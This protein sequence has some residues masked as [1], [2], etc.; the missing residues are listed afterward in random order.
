MATNGVQQRGDF[1]RS[2]HLASLAQVF[3]H[4]HGTWA[5]FGSFLQTLFGERPSAGLGVAPPGIVGCRHTPGGRHYPVLQASIGEPLS[6]TMFDHE[7][8]RRPCICIGSFDINKNPGLVVTDICVKANRFL[9]SIGRGDEADYSG[10]DR[11]YSQPL[12]PSSSPLTAP[13]ES[14]AS[15]SFRSIDPT[16][17]LDSRLRQPGGERAGESQGLSSTYSE[18]F[19]DDEDV[20]VELL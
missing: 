4:R 14:A 10:R 17:V 2:K 20:Q 13:Q 15:D 12:D 19:F 9:L 7:R 11:D 5:D 6:Y 8:Y 18:E 16:N 1:G 3:R